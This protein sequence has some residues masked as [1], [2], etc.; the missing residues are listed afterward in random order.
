M[1]AILIVCVGLLIVLAGCKRDEYYIDGGKAQADFPGNMME[2]L[3]Q[4]PVPFDTI[5]QIVKLAGMEDT[6]RNADFTFFAPDDDVVKRTIG[7]FTRGGLNRDLYEEGRDTVKQLSDISPVVWRKF[8]T[9]YMFAGVNRLKDY[10]QIDL[11]LQSQYP[12][13]LY[14]STGNEVCNI[15]VIYGDANGVRYIGPRRLHIMFVPD[16]AN[17]TATSYPTYISSSDIKPRNGVVHTLA[18]SGAYF[19]F[20]YNE[21]YSD[22]YFTGLTSS[23]N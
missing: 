20:N 3:E 18:Y 4:K 15:G 16:V 17:P 6:F 19:G 8:L 12:G 11:N 23:G 1:K 21:F 13:Q 5:A 7:S 14:Y 22:V 10:P 9:R 2:Y